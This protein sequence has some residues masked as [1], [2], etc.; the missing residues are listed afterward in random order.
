MINN[1]QCAN[2]LNASSRF[3]FDISIS[4]SESLV[5]HDQPRRVMQNHATHM[6][7]SARHPFEAMKSALE[8]RGFRYVPSDSPD[9]FV[10]GGYSNPSFVDGSGVV[11]SLSTSP[12]YTRNG[13]VMRGYPPVVPEPELTLEAIYVPEISRGKGMASEALKKVTDAA[14][15]VG[16]DLALEPTPI[17]PLTSK[18]SLKQKQLV[19]WYK[20]HGWKGNEGDFDMVL[21]RKPAP[22]KA[23]FVVSIK[24]AN[25]ELP[26]VMYHGTSSE[27][28]DDIMNKGLFHPY[29]AVDYDKAMYYAEGAVEFNGGDPIVLEVPTASLDKSLLRYDNHEMDEPSRTADEESRNEAWNAAA[30]EHPDWK[31]EVDNAIIHIPPEAWEFSLS[32]V[33][34]V[35]YY[36]TVKL[37]ERNASLR[38]DFDIV[39]TASRL[40]DRLNEKAK[41]VFDVVGDVDSAEYVLSDG[42]CISLRGDDHRA[43]AELFTAKIPKGYYNSLGSSSGYMLAFMGEAEAIRVRLSSSNELV[44]SF[45]K[46]ATPEQISVILGT[47]ANKVYADRLTTMYSSVASAHFSMPSERMMLKRFLELKSDDRDEF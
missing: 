43:V 21:T 14:D 39:I 10:S 24:T 15:E 3:D 30:E 11:V 37:N 9:A 22:R 27:L 1:R 23:S 47:S 31:N 18:K 8:S 42:T 13:R 32:G 25:L 36:G 4:L 38:S 33:G 17:K 20:R 19:D 5:P 40:G 44:I 45:I 41:T 29:L 28:L 16:I 7:S 26:A 46:K 35:M 6:A 12:V 2:R 34:T